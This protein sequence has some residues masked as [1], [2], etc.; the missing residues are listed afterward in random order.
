METISR[1]QAQV[2]VRERGRHKVTVIEAL[3]RE[4]YDKFHLPGAKNVPFDADFDE[5]IQQAVPDKSSPVMIYCMNSESEASPQAA[6]RMD[7]L[8]Y[9]RVFA[10]EAGK[11]D[12]K[13]AGLKIER[14]F[15]VR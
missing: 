3:S 11:V 4:N 5:N 7:E 15:P 10:Y 2:L 9:S 14:E 13:Q 8:G 1:E 6:K 12:W